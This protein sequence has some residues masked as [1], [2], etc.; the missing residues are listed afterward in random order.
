MVEAEVQ[1]V[2]RGWFRD[3]KYSVQ[4]EVELEGGNRIDLVA[5][6]EGE[7]WFVEVKGD[8][9][10]NVA[11]Y[12]VNFDTGM[13]QL[14][15]GMARLDDQTK[16]AIGI[17]ISRTERGERLSYRLVLPKYS[18]SL[19]FEALSIHFLLVRDDESVEAIAPDKARAFLNTVD[20]RIRMRQ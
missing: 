17:P 11:Q 14:L 2:L 4:G 9:D 10:N 1:R 13:G 15:K 18:R 16:Y 5:K 19:V 20:P 6:S 7:E 8:Y 12:S 3:R